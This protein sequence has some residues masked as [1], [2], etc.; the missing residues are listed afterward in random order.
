MCAGSI[1][2]LDVNLFFSEEEKEVEDEHQSAEYA[3]TVQVNKPQQLQLEA[4]LD[5]MIAEGDYR[6]KG[7]GKEASCL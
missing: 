5:I 4:E 7:L 3:G 6:G 1:P 2:A